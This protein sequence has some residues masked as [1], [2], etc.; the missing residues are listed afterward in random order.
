MLR[1]T[2][3]RGDII[4]ILDFPMPAGLLR[5]GRY[6]G[7]IVLTL[8]SS[9]VLDPNQGGE[10]CQSDIEVK[11]GSYDELSERDITKPTILNPIGR[12]GTTNL[13]LPSRYSKRKMSGASEDFAQ[14]ERML[15]QYGGKYYPVKKYAI[16]LNELTDSNLAAIEEDKHWFLFLKGT[17]RD[18]AERDSKLTGE[19]LEQDFCLIVTIRDPEKS[20]DVYNEVAQFLDAHGFWHESVRINNDVRV[21]VG[22]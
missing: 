7:Q 14:R 5:G 3:A 16:D 6:S 18:A 19:V 17:Y 13:L 8:V 2:L 4:D 15:I 1:G 10:Y 21:R 11:F 12:S 9:P 20:A 22:F